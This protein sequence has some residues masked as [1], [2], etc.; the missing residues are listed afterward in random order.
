MLLYLNVTIIRNRNVTSPIE[1]S[2]LLTLYEF[3]NFLLFIV[4]QIVMMASSSDTGKVPLV[5]KFAFTGFKIDK[6]KWFATCTKCNTTL[7]EKKSV[8]SGFT[9]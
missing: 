3:I 9:K 4:V 2:L 5:I 6:D 8:T 7:C 1:T